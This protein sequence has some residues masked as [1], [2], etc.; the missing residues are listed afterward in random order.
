M[1]KA[2]LCGILVLGIIGCGEESNNKKSQCELLANELINLVKT[3][4]PENLADCGGNPTLDNP[5]ITYSAA[6]IDQ[7][8]AL[9][10]ANC[11]LPNL[12]DAPV[13]CATTEPLCP[14]NYNCG[15]KQGI[16][17]CLKNN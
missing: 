3:S 16:K 7:Q 5:M 8:T 17:M 6:M 4:C 1:N 12:G 15:L 14:E 2:L 11:P 9:K 10:N 13:Y